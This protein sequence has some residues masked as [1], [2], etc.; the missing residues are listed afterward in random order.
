MPVKLFYISSLTNIEK[1]MPKLEDEINRFEKELDTQ[2]R[3]SKTL[4]PAMII[5]LY[6]A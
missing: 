5:P 1:N 3:E 6:T 4:R 2:E